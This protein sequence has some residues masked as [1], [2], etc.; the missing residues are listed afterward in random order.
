MVPSPGRNPRN[1]K[2]IP[3][4]LNEFF[5]CH[6]RFTRQFFD[7][8]VDISAEVGW[9]VRI[10][11]DFDTAAEKGED[12]A[13]LEIRSHNGIGHWAACQANV[14][15]YDGFDQRVVLDNVGPMVNTVNLDFVDALT[16]VSDGICLVDIAL[17][18]GDQWTGENRWRQ[19]DLSTH[20]SSQ[21]E[22]FLTGSLENSSKFGRW[23]IPLVR[24]QA[25][26]DDCVFVRQ[27]FHQRG[28]GIFRGLVTQ[29]AK[30]QAS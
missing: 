3:L 19:Q 27:G 13:S 25:N 21:E 26:A 28:H 12:F 15:G 14:L 20:M 11:S 10:D 2:C 29:E 22:T 24:V 5:T 9:I 4:Q 8:F 16:D 1:A 17:C 30:D 23:I 6:I 18:L 7:V